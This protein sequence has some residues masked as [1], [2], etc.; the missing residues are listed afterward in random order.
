MEMFLIEPAIDQTE[1]VRILKKPSGL[2]SMK[3]T[4]VKVECFH[5]PIFIFEIK[6]R[7]KRGNPV[8]HEVCIDGIQGHF[9]LIQTANLPKHKPDNQ[10]KIDFNLNTAD[11]ADKARRQFRNHMH[12]FRPGITIED[13]QLASKAWYPYW[14]GFYSSRKGFLFDVI[15]GCNGKMQGVKMKSLFSEVIIKK[16]G[17]V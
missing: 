8:V 14:T 17:Y 9:A 3:R 6:T 1:A 11:A 7:D 12:R 15:D 2:F 4:L 13:I 16:S 5:L 10:P